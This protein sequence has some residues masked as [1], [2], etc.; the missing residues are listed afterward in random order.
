M[1]LVSVFSGGAGDKLMFALQ[2][3]PGKMARKIHCSCFLWDVP[4][5]TEILLYK[6]NTTVSKAFIAKVNAI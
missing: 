5:I 1:Q 6:A 4:Q 3:L 2:A